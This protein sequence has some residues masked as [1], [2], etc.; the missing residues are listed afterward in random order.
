MTDTI[1]VT[2]AEYVRR[3]R[4]YEFL[5]RQQKVAKEELDAIL[6]TLKDEIIESGNTSMSRTSGAR[7]G[8][9]TTNHVKPR[10]GDVPNVLDWLAS[11][12]QDLDV[13]RKVNVDSTKL[14]RF[15][16]EGIEEGTLDEDELPEELNIYEET[17]VSVTNWEALA[18][19]FA[20]DE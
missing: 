3:R 11:K 12:G 18:S 5:S 13:Y 16:D 1:E 10:V 15:V 4:R 7:V 14:R 20:T 19:E 6:A 2:L 8:V 9:R 17:K